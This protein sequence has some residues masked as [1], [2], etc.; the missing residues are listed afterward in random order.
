MVWKNDGRKYSWVRGIK[1]GLV[2]AAAVGAGMAAGV[3][4]LG[5]E[6]AVQ[7]VSVVTV[8]TVAATVVRVALNWWKVNQDMAD[9][10]YLR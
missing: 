3:E 8:I 5:S 9:K 1:K 4:L 6:S 10:R 2:A 7:E